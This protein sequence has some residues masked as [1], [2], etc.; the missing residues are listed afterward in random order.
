MNE[1]TLAKLN[2]ELDRLP[3]SEVRFEWDAALEAAAG[4][5][6]FPVS[7]QTPDAASHQFRS[8]ATGDYVT[9]RTADQRFH[10]Q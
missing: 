7:Q 9:Y 2:S 10:A 3:L 6:Y 4:F 5:G 8:K 1:T